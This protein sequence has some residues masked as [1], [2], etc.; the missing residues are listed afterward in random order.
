MWASR[1]G[2]TPGGRVL[3]VN[4]RRYSA[5]QLNDVLKASPNVTAPIELILETGEMFTTARV[6]YHGGARFP[7]LERI[8]G[9]PDVL[10]LI[11]KPLAQ[12]KK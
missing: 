3:A 7:H 6:D 4:G 9:K 1:A 11:G 8:E 5:E 12:P 2:V 10:S